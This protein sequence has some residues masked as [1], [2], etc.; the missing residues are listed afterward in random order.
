LLIDKNEPKY[1]RSRSRYSAS[2]NHFD[3]RTRE[4]VPHNRSGFQD[5]FPKETREIS[6]PRNQ[7]VENEETKM[8]EN[9]LED[10]GGK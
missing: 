5:K 3:R 10:K 7:E 2:S 8:Q 9:G 6:V 1:A 4:R